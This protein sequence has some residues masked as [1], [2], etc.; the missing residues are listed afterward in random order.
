M[1]TSFVPVAFCPFN[2]FG[3][4]ALNHKVFVRFH[5]VDDVLNLRIDVRP[6]QVQ[7]HVGG[8]SSEELDG[9]VIETEDVGVHQNDNPLNILTLGEYPG[10]LFE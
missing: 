8:A 9:D 1:L 7:D 2:I 10:I 4:C 3:L 6:G 5:V